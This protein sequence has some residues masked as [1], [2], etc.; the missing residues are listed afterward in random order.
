[1]SFS[2]NHRGVVH[3]AFL[4]PLAGWTGS[5]P[6]ACSLV[7]VLSKPSPLAVGSPSLSS[8][9]RPPEGVLERGEEEEEKNMDGP[10]RGP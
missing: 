7:V 2:I 10:A 6:V 3:E 8:F 9:I 1:M 5:I 4:G